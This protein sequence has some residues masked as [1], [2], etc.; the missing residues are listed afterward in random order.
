MRSDKEVE[1]AMSQEVQVLALVKGDQKFVF[2][3]DDR[4][5]RSLLETFG[6]YAADPELDFTWYDAAVLSEK[7]RLLEH[8]TRRHRSRVDHHLSI[9]EPEAGP[10]FPA[11]PL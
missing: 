5:S 9:S 8:T 2:L 10:S 3:F 7:V 6:R 1:A 11:E 4:S